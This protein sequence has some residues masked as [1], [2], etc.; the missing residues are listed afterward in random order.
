VHVVDLDGDPAFDS[1]GG[2][3]AVGLVARAPVGVEVDERLT[4]QL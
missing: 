3:R 2:Q 1:G 4:G